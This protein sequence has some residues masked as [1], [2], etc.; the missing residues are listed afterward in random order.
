MPSQFNDLPYDAN[1]PDNPGP[2]NVAYDANDPDNPGPGD[3]PYDAST[4][5]VASSDNGTAKSAGT[6]SW[7]K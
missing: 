6:V 7:H 3:V 1:D 2:G 4:D 5:A